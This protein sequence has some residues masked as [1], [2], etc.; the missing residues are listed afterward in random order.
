MNKE[1]DVHIL[2][3]DG[4][5]KA[6]EIATIFNNTLN[7]LKIVCPDGREFSI[8]KTKLEEACFFAKKAMASA[9]VKD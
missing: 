5:G 2:T 4:I 8:V 1:F 3:E 6:K 7:L 9:N